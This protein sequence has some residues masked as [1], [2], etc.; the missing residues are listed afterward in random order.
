MMLPLPLL[1]LTMTMTHPFYANSVK[2]IN[3]VQH[4]YWI[5]YMW[6]DY[7]FFY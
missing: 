1:P 5:Q 2:L 7:V 6:R 4:W 3:E